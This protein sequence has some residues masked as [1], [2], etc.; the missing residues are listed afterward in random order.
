MVY[1]FPIPEARGNGEL[2]DTRGKRLEHVAEV[3]DLGL[4]RV[5]TYRVDQ[6]TGKLQLRLHLGF[7]GSLS[8]KP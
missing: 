4:D 3:P 8:P 5:V 2:H 6:S 1:F 7:G